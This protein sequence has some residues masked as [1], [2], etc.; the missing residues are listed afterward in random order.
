MSESPHA[1]LLAS[2]GTGKTHR[3]TSHYLRLLFAGVEPSR[4]L[5][6]T[7]TRKAAGEIFDRVLERLTNAVED[8]DARRSLEEGVGR[9]IGAAEG[10]ERLAGLARRLDRLRIGTLDAFFAELA[11]I[12]ALDLGLPPDWRIAGNSTAEELH[13]EAVGRVLAAAGAAERLDLLR[14]LQKEAATRSVH[15]ALLDLVAGARAVHLE[16]APGAWECVRPGPA[17]DAGELRALGARLETLV[18]PATKS[19]KPRVH[20]KNG[21]AAIRQHVAEGAWDDFLG[22]TLVARA[23]DETPTFDRT[24]IPA[25]WLAVLRPLAA[26]ASAV[27]L[28]RLARQNAATVLFLER[29]EAAWRAIQ[30]ERGL[31]R[32][33]DLPAAL[34]PGGPERGRPLEERELDLWYRLDAQIDHVLLDEFQDTAPAQWRVLSPLVDEVLADGTGWRSFFCVGDE[35]QSIYGWRQAEPRL[36][37][38]LAARPGLVPEPLARSYRSSSVVLDAVNAF[39]AGAGENAAL[40]GDAHEARRRAARRWSSAHVPHAAAK[41]L[42]G[43]V[44]L[45]EALSPAPGEDRDAP[46]LRLAADRAAALA[47]ATPGA[48]IGILVRQRK[49]IP[50]LIYLLRERGQ[51]ASGEGGNPLTDSAA[52]LALLSL[53]HLADHPADRAAAFHVASSPFGPA[54]DLPPAAGGTVPADRARAAAGR[55]RERLAREGYGPFCA[56]LHA[57][58]VTAD[59]RFTAWDR[60]RFACLVE[61]AHAFDAEAGLRPAAFA[62]H[63]RAT[64]VEDPAAAQV[65][66]MTIHAAKGLEFDAVLLPE[67]NQPLGRHRVEILASRP[68]P[69]GPIRAASHAASQ[70]L[71]RTNAALQ[72]LAA[73]TVEREFAE[74]LAVLYVAMTRAARRLEMIVHAPGKN[75]LCYAALLRAAFAGPPAVSVPDTPATARWRHGSDEGWAAGLESAPAAAP[76]ADL[77]ALR[78]APSRAPRLL[79]HRSPSAA[80]GGPAR[81]AALLRPRDPAATARGSLVH[82]WLEDLEWIEDFAA[83]DAELLDR[84]A[85]IEPDLERRRAALAE[86]RRALAS[87][88]IRAAL[89]RPAGESPEVRREHAFSLFLPEPDGGE[90]LWTG[91]ID[92][93]V[94]HRRGGELVA[95]EVIDYKTDRV[96]PAELALRAE[97]YRPQLDAY[98]RIAA[99]L[100]GLPPAAIAARLVFL[101]PEEVVEV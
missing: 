12:F 35:K 65:R 94:L 82:R 40:A 9:R 85:R 72:A 14:S 25:D 66:V 37:G 43:A 19:G 17:L 32:F 33:E 46:A 50:R 11:R 57:E 29:F 18:P 38:S 53:V 77:P 42:P 64:K 55:V 56:A 6:T 31:L 20:W 73:E 84:G 89:A 59:A 26:H 34:A 10:E 74:D 45:W 8:E 21:L 52:V 16:S 97:H 36:L 2:A 91:A 81:A 98:R 80:E 75:E 22:A 30:G 83:S 4:I 49:R 90:A 3:L 67:L 27:L 58:L 79:P 70:A 5:A 24:E 15:A 62:D 92:R 87:P 48:R 76:P 60:R 71:A 47:T 63:V 41:D 1:L 23:L 51:R 99:A 68:D 7:F 61:L 39:F 93:L 100:T 44:V 86:L 69:A 54:F 101:A 78:L 95:A 13:A 88:A 96:A 28:A